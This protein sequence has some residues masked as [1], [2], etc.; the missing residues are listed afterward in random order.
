MAAQ[1][2]HDPQFL[3]DAVALTTA[4][5]GCIRLRTTY[6][7][8]QEVSPGGHIIFWSNGGCRW[9]RDRIHGYIRAGQIVTL[10]ANEVIAPTRRSAII[11]Y[12]IDNRLI[13][14]LPLYSNSFE[15]RHS[16]V[17]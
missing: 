15:A 7:R 9:L 16:G 13:V 14:N 1:N 12:L 2:D 3:D 5:N 4:L 10:D 11:D 6:G 8:R 17:L